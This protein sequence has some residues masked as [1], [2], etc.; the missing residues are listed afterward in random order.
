MYIWYDL[1]KVHAYEKCYKVLQKLKGKL[2]P[3]L[4][5]LTKIL[6]VWILKLHYYYYLKQSKRY[7]NMQV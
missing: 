2:I 5:L 3:F 1:Y 4:L 6:G 7:H